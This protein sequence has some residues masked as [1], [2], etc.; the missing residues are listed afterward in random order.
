M[1]RVSIPLWFVFL[2]TI[3]LATRVAQANQLSSPGLNSMRVVVQFE[4]GTEVVK[5]V[6]FPEAQISGL[7]ALQRSGLALITTPAG[8]VCSIDGQGCP[9][10]KCFTCSPGG[11]F[12]AYWRWIDGHWVPSNVGAA[13]ARVGNGA[14]DGWRWTNDLSAPPPPVYQAA[15]NRALA[16]LQ[17]Q[18]QP[19]GSFPTNE[20]GIVV[21]VV[22]AGAAAGARP[23]SWHPAG[24][25]S[26]LAYLSTQADT[27]AARS[28][29][30]AGKL[31]VAVTAAGSDPVNFGG[32]DLLAKI[33]GYY[34]PTS[35]QFGTN[36]NNWDQ[37]WSILALSAASESIP[38]TA[39]ARL[40]A[41][42][43]SDGAWGYA[44][45]IAKDV[46]STALA[47]QALI[48]AGEPVTSTIVAKALNY[49]HS[50]QLPDAGFPGGQ[51]LT[52]SVSSI[53][54]AT[55]GLIATGQNPLGNE[56]KKDGKTP[57]DALLA[58]QSA[59][60]SF[61]SLGSGLPATLQSTA[62]AIPALFGRPFP[63]HGRAVAARKALEWMRAH[64][65][66]DGG[67]ST[68][69]PASDLG[70]TLDAVFA[71]AAAGQNPDTWKP[72]GQSPLDFAA[73][74]VASYTAQTDT[75]AK[76]ALAVVAAGRDPS[77]FAGNDL[78]A[79]VTGSLTTTGQYGQTLSDHI[80]ALLALDAIHRPIPRAALDWLKAQQQPN[81]GWDQGFGINTN[82]TALALQALAVAGEPL[83][84]TTVLSATHYLRAQQNS[85]GGFPYTKPSPYGTDTD[86]NST[87]NVIQGLIAV[88]QDPLSWTWMTALTAT[89][90]ITLT[91][92]DPE[93]RLMALQNRSGAFRF[94]ASFPDDNAFATY[95]AVPALLERPLPVR[96]QIL[97][98]Y[99]PLVTRNR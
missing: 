55:Q 91:Q 3:G 27:Y 26:P 23:E 95:Q 41:N 92:H 14:I 4:N 45:G 99:L 81:G 57:L 85:D 37:A 54:F 8:A 98:A 2:A 13:Q 18:Q 44:P 19:D 87:A 10:D 25:K 34:Q 68:F 33:R 63:L 42:Q 78:V 79:Q 29:A 77:S 53:G 24:G 31:A 69:S 28:P 47:L 35:G 12:W 39:T 1:N 7:E 15:A 83:N 66:A 9:A 58:L 70:A 59:D 61:A 51:G 5:S 64:Q 16:W 46:D 71:I 30:A 48:A 82:T 38:L 80:W 60:G 84:S 72:A 94:Q 49:L 62:Q 6:D 32:V 75:T 20:V 76:L 96:R 93:S 17:A 56:W 73:T 11:K 90:A 74:R 50:R 89:N 40:K 22:L 97:H 88:R 86:A 36:N 65:N 21:D 43:E 67:F 52:V